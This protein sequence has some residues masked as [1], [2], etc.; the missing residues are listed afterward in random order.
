MSKKRILIYTLGI[1]NLQTENASFPY[2]EKLLKKVANT[3]VPWKV[4]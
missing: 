1:Y 4:P 2:Q 3:K